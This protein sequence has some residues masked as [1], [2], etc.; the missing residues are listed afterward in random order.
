MVSLQTDAIFK[1]VD[2][3]KSKQTRNALDRNVIS[4]MDFIFRN[5]A[6]LLISLNVFAQEQES[7]LNIYREL[8]MYLGLNKY[9]FA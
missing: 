4:D 3:T 8:N 2:F 9:Y 7:W 5:R 1:G 6:C